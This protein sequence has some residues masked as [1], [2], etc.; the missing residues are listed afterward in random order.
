MLTIT[1]VAVFIATVQITTVTSTFLMSSYYEDSSCLGVPTFASGEI[2]NGTDCPSQATCNATENPEN[3]SVPMYTAAICNSSIFEVV[4]WIYS[5][6]PYLLQVKY[7][8]GLLVEG[9]AYLADGDWHPLMTINAK[10]SIYSDGA[11]SGSKYQNGDNI[12]SAESWDI[13]GDWLRTNKL[14]AETGQGYDHFAFYTNRFLWNYSNESREGNSNDAGFA[15][16]PPNNSVSSTVTT[17]LMSSYYVDSSC[18]GIPVFVDAEIINSID[19]PAQP[20]CNPAEHPEFYSVPLKT[21]V[22]C[23]SS[24]FQAVDMIY[25]PTMYLLQV[26][27]L[28]GSFVEG[29]AFLAD[30]AWHPVKELHSKITVNSDGSVNGSYYTNG[31]TIS[32]AESWYLT[33][34]IVRTHQLLEGDGDRYDHF[35]F[36][37]NRIQ[38]TPPPPSAGASSGGSNDTNHVTA[39]PNSSTPTRSMPTST[40]QPAGFTYLATSAF[41]DARCRGPP[42]ISGIVLADSR[43]CPAQPICSTAQISEFSAHTNWSRTCASTVFNAANALYGQS[44]YFLQVLYRNGSIVAGSVF[45][46]DGICHNDGDGSMRVS[47]QSDGSVTYSLYD[48]ENCANISTS[49]TQN[50]SSN[51]LSTHELVAIDSGSDFDHIAY[52]MKQ[53]LPSST[54]SP[55]VNS[56]GSTNVTSIANITNTPTPTSTP[57]STKTT[58]SASANNGLYFLIVTLLVHFSL[59]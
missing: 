44:A 31:D 30:S 14:I 17:I 16:P 37:T 55:T 56:T 42:V 57:T 23:A 4:D 8:N 53:A 54:G 43:D 58:S 29:H 10:I 2:S 46:A 40:V 39:A 25:G 32:N 7:L 26:M 28:N 5:H 52:Y 34:D 9:Q 19:C 36:Y 6:I 38:S 51:L 33:S 18:R 41:E 22:M 49:T 50:V 13:P 48:Q 12:S 35:A 3:F 47:I 27:Y 21:S 15:P 24:M 1:P 59:G 11:V 45:L 20:N